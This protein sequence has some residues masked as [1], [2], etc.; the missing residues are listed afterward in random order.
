MTP[1]VCQVMH[2]RHIQL[3][4]GSNSEFTINN[5]GYTV[6]ITW[7]VKLCLKTKNKFNAI[8]GLLTDIQHLFEVQEHFL[9]TKMWLW[10]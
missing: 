6:N 5:E 7:S 1:D 10:Y 2:S 9:L 8:M 4:M 3:K